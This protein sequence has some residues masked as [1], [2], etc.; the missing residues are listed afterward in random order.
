VINKKK[1][2]EYCRANNINP[3]QVFIE[4]GESAKSVNRAQFLRAIAFSTNKK[5]KIDTFVVYKVDRFARNMHDHFAVKKTLMDSGVTLRSVTEQI[6][7]DP[8]EKVMEGILAVIAEFDNDVRAKR[9]TDG[10]SAKI[11]QGIY[12][13]HPPTGYTHGSTQR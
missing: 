12:P 6:G 10:M 7:N 13:W 3:V 11:N 5:N 1:C 4:K 9:S 2:E 8:S